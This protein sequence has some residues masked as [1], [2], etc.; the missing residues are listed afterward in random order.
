MACYNFFVGVR[1]ICAQKIKTFSV[2]QK[3]KKIKD[4]K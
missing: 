1:C 4:R 3:Y 2:R